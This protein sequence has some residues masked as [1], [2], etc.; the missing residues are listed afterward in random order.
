VDGWLILDAFGDSKPIEDVFV[1]SMPKEMVESKSLHFFCV[2]GEP[3]CMAWT[4]RPLKF[5]CSLAFVYTSPKHRHKGYGAA[6]VSLSAEEL[7][8]KYTYVTLLVDSNRNPEDNLY[9]RIGYRYV[10][11]AGHLARENN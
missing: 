5:R 4:R 2:Q 10:G 1:E 7:L 11:E 6:C 9:T 3:V 8:K